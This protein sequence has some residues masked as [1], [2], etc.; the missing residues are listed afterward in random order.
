MT[1]T[2]SSATTAAEP[3]VK[4]PLYQ[5][6]AA[7]QFVKFCIVGFS[8]TIINYLVVNIL[9]YGLHFHV[10]QSV[11]YG[12]VLSCVNGFIWNRQWTFKQSRGHS[13]ATQSMRFIAV[14][15]V[16]LVLNCSIVAFIIAL[17]ESTRGS[18]FDGQHLISIILAIASQ[19][20]KFEVPK[21]VL[22]GGLFVATAVVVFWNFFANRYWT[23]KHKQPAV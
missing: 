7:R 8:S 4:A 2:T 11:A 18:A 6:P 14:N 1:Y 19:Q 13:A 3:V 10:L 15:T 21:L 23:F 12:F 20:H 5:T 22:N 9:H 16:G 17:Y